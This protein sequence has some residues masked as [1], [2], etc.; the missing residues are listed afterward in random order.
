MPE[1]R[2]TLRTK[3]DV[4]RVEVVDRSVCDVEQL[5]PRAVSLVGKGQGST[6]VTLWFGDD[7]HRPVTCLVRVMPRPEARQV[8][9]RVKIAELK[10]P[11]AGEGGI[12]W[13]LE[14]SQHGSLLDALARA[15]A[16]A[17][18]VILDGLDTDQIESRL[19]RLEQQDR[20][21]VVSR[22]TLTTSSGRP[23][24]IATGDGAPE[25]TIGSAGSGSPKAA[26]LN[27]AL[28][29]LPV[30]TDNEDVQ[31]HVAAEFSPSASEPGVDA[32]KGMTIRETATQVRLHPGQ[33]LVIGSPLHELKEEKG[34]GL[35]PIISQ[36]IGY[37]EPKR[38][39]AK[40]VVLITPELVPQSER[41]ASLA[42]FQGLQPGEPA[43]RR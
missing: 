12:D 4:A 26:D 28:T 35:L 40:L 10:R 17:K 5:G 34:R 9:F 3:I 33:T 37:R 32:A 14:S 31:L 2:K 29:L 20:L 22:P 23:A 39:Q 16:G 15:E 18:P 11:P 7:R 43:L 24:T 13:D 38:E 41:P 19:R 1:R 21:R 36:V 25:T 6:Q 27:A 8:V 42:S 30:V